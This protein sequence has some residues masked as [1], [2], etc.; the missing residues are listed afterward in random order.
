[1]PDGPKLAAVM[2]GAA[3]KALTAYVDTAAGLTLMATPPT[4]GS[5]ARVTEKAAFGITEWD[6]SN[7]VK[8]VLKPTTFKADE[9][10]FRATSPGGTSQDT[11]ASARWAAS[12]SGWHRGMRRQIIDFCPC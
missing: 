8:V 1:M 10:V 6:L 11:T 3:S 12:S 2:A 4:P 7:G 9:V 5:I